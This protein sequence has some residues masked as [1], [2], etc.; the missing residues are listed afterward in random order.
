MIVGYGGGDGAD[1]VFLLDRDA[2]SV[3]RCDADGDMHERALA[4]AS[5]VGADASS[6]RSGATSVSEGKHPRA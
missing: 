6:L 1:V 2:I 4:N 5:A 3:R